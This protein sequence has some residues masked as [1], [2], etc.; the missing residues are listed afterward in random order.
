MSIGN[1]KC[2]MLRRAVLVLTFPVFAPL[3]LFGTM[4]EC[5]MQA[6]PEIMAA[7]RNAWKAK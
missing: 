3:V 1:I 7:Y 4:I 6:L 5:A 2:L